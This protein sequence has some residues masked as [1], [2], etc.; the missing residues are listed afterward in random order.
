M[1]PT[2]PASHRGPAKYSHA[3]AFCLMTYR[4][5]DGTEEEVIWNSR[6]GVTPFVITLRSGRKASHV[7][8][9]RDR[10]VLDYSP[11]AGSRIFVDL[12]ADAARQYAAA[13]AER[14]FAEGPEARQQYGTVE[15]MALE[16]AAEYLS[17]P[18][19]PDLVEAP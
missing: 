9:H 14:W 16:L 5:D 10:R 6:D 15:A 19:A 7:D 12:T 8:W 11:P 3:E 18:G 1:E 4:S 13:N 2:M 17:R